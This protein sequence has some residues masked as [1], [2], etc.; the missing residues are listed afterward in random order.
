MS[1]VLFGVASAADGL[2]AIN[3]AAMVVVIAIKCLN[4]FNVRSPDMSNY[5]LGSISRRYCVLDA[6]GLDA[7]LVQDP[8]SD[9]AD[10]VVEAED[11]EGQ[12]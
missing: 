12:G 11:A 7:D 9:G 2:A 10:F 8:R 3:P 6:T 5:S 4:I 1:E